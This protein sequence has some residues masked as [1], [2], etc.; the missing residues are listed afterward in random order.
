MGEF[1]DNHTLDIDPRG[2]IR[3]RIPVL[4]AQRLCNSTLV[5]FVGPSLISILAHSHSNV[6]LPAPGKVRIG[7]L[8][9]RF[10]VLAGAFCRACRRH[11]LSIRWRYHRH[12]FI[13]NATWPAAI[14]LSPTPNSCG[15]TWQC[16]VILCSARSQHCATEA[17]DYWL[18]SRTSPIKRGTIN[19]YGRG[20][21]KVAEKTLFLLN[22]LIYLN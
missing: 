19:C 20:V 10:A 6:P 15:A 2:R 13:V 8:T 1:L 12:F 9:V 3:T 22:L 4:T 21:K 17:C 18:A 14:E 16:D 5:A 7:I 11:W